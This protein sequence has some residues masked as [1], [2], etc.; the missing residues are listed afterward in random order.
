MERKLRSIG[1]GS[2]LAPLA[3]CALVAAL[4]ISAWEAYR[5]RPHLLPGVFW[6]VALMLINVP[7]FIVYDDLPYRTARFLFVMHGLCFSCLLLAVLKMKG[8]IRASL[9]VAGMAGIYLSSW[10]WAEYADT[11]D[12]RS[13]R[14]HRT[15]HPLPFRRLLRG[16]PTDLHEGAVYRRGRHPQ[17]V[18][19]ARDPEGSRR[20]RESLLPPSTTWTSSSSTATSASAM[21]STMDDASPSAPFRT[22]PSSESGPASTSPTMNRY[23]RVKRAS[24]TD[25]GRHRR[26]PIP[27]YST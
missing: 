2:D 11:P 3:L 27:G 19:P 16:Q 7:N 23:G 4:L 18:P 10:I 12:T 15:R 20:S 22:M 14:R 1:R 24:S 25:P 8:M 13:D 21:D 17:K 5:A 6:I 9:L 26:T